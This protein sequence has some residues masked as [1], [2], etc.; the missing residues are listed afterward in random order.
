MG[1]KFC[2]KIWNA[3]R[4]VLQQ[5]ES[6]KPQVINYKLNLK[7]L[8]LADK[9]VLEKLNKAIKSM[10]KDLENL[11]LGRAAHE[12][13]D[14]FWHDFCDKYIEQA[15]LQISNSK[16]K[17][18]KESAQKI[19]L[20]VLLASL[21]LLHPFIPFITEEIYQLLPLKEKEK[22]LMIEKWPASS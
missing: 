3:S 9:A 16:P 17:D 11:Q 2:N 7:N 19:L 22:C 8:T 5:I 13:Y 21:K 6:S 4:F 20:Y 10:N 18:K 14:F 1:R 12:I 15:K